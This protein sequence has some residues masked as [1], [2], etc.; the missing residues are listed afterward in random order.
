[1][2]TENTQ[3]AVALSTPDRIRQVQDELATLNKVSDQPYHSIGKTIADVDISTCTSI[4]DLIELDATIRTAQAAYDRS[5]ADKIGKA[6]IKGA[7]PYAIKG[8]PVDQIV[9]DIDLRLQILSIEERRTFLADIQKGYEELMDKNDKQAML[10]AK[11]QAY[12]SK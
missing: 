11:L 6:L 1:M 7:K 8:V 3:T 10:D 12:L 2:S 9:L 4:E 5:L